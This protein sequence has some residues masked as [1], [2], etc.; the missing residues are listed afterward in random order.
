MVQSSPGPIADRTFDTAF[1]VAAVGGVVVAVLLYWSGALS[2]SDGSDLL[3][4]FILFPVYLV[5]VAALLGVWL[6]YDT[7]ASDLV[8]VRRDAEPTES[9]E[10]QR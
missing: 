10:R 8:R 4:T 9:R 6:G 1:K 5:A 2:L 7:D 3:Y